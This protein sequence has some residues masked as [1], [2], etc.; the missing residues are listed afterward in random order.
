VSRQRG[1]NVDKW[2]STRCVF[3][4]VPGVFEERVTLWEAESLDAA[5]QMAE[6]EAF[7][8]SSKV[9]G[10]Q[11]VFTGLIQAFEV[12]LNRPESGTEVF[13]LLRDSHLSSDAYLT[14]YFDT[15]TEHQQNS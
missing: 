13:S 8:Y 15:G 4:W 9:E 14:K 2:Y 11:I 10:H 12:G 3:E 1:D 6:R 5:I 7:N